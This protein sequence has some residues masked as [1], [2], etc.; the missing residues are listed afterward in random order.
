MVH[1]CTETVGSWRQMTV[2]SVWSALA[3]GKKRERGEKKEDRAGLRAN[4]RRVPNNLLSRI[5]Q[6]VGLIKSSPV[7]FW[8]NSQWSSCNK[9]LHRLHTEIKTRTQFHRWGAESKWCC[10]SVFLHQVSPNRHVGA[11]WLIVC[12]NEWINEWLWSERLCSST[13]GRHKKKQNKR[14]MSST[15]GNT[16]CGGAA[17]WYHLPLYVQY[18]GISISD[19]S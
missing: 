12:V 17:F 4:D 14:K 18:S 6:M 15:T 9:E 7:Y 8:I 2:S 5:R 13:R 10:F 1:F 19:I 16:D 11:D 3:E